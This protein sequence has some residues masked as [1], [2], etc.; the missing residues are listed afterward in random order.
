M[1]TGT[2]DQWATQNAKVC[3]CGCRYEQHINGKGP[4]DACRRCTGFREVTA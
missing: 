1:I 2:T 4:C 3:V